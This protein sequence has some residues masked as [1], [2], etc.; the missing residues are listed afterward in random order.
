[1]NRQKLI[2][3]ARRC[4]AYGCDGC[5]YNDC[6]NCKDHVLADTADLLESDGRQIAQMEARLTGEQKQPEHCGAAG[7][8]E[9]GKNMLTLIWTIIVVISWMCGFVIG[10]DFGR[11]G[12]D[13]GSGDH[14]ENGE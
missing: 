7:A 1:M 11:K 13:D 2:E 12:S 6:E 10:I 14:R 9:G 4:L 8:A 3:Q 5:V